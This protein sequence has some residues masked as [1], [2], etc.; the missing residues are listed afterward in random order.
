MAGRRITLMILIFTAAFALGAQEPPLFSSSDRCVAC[1]SAL[2]TAAGEDVSIGT[3][4]SASMMGNSA[5]DPYWQAAVRRETA[6]HPA[7]SAEIQHECSAC[8]MPMARYESKLRD[9]HGR[10]FAN[11]PVGGVRTREA[12]LAADGVSCTSCHTMEPTHFGERTSF[13]AGFVVSPPTRQGRKAYGPYQVDA[14]RTRIMSSATGFAPAKADHLA[15]AE[16]CATCHTLFTHAIHP[17]GSTGAEFPE[18]VP[19]LEW[20]HSAYASTKS[21]QS[22]HMPRSAQPSMISSVLGEERPS[23]ARHSFRGGNFFI[24][25]LLDA[26]RMELGVTAGHSDF[27]A[28]IASTMEHL[29][30]D[31][32]TVSV[33]NVALRGNRL[34]AEVAVTNMAG[35]KL[36]TAYPSRRAW[37]HCVVRNGSGAV[38]FES[39]SLSA[40]G[41]IAGNDHDADPLRFEPHYISINDSSQVQIYEPVMVDSAGVPTTALLKAVRYVKDNRILPAGFDKASA[42]A[43]VRVHGE[44]AGDGDF[45]A[46]S[47]RI[48]Y[49]VAVDPAEGPFTVIVEL[50]YQPIGFR[51][52]ENFRGME[53]EEPKRFVGYYEKAAGRSA[54]VMARGEAVWHG[55]RASAD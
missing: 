3:A 10:V 24:P 21:C 42:P 46:G 39:G 11:L 48:R 43:E 2:K 9:E 51:W 36:P 5:R 13:N 44:A 20:K 52:A 26:H 35:H 8:H 23:M 53:L 30:H 49:S 47:D 54:A 15:S 28:S 31:A 4:W 14:G 34:E 41:S 22:C 32:A 37:L 6:D 12:M 25:A 16:M 38:V 45:V 33:E 27:K 7:A 29:R 50:L 55:Q 18:Q 40:D 1:H 19:Y 17:D